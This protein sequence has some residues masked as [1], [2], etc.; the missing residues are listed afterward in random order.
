M[1][2]V[3]VKDVLENGVIIAK[4]QNEFKENSYFVAASALLNNQ[5]NI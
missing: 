1:A 4:D 3:G 5:E 2:F